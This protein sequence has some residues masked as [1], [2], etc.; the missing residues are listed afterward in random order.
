MLFDFV[1][2]GWKIHTQGNSQVYCKES[3]KHVLKHHRCCSSSV[4]LSVLLSYALGAIA[5]FQA[6]V[7]MWVLKEGE[8]IATCKVAK[9]E[10]FL[11]RRNSQTEL[12]RVLP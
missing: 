4:C 11:E 6:L 7:L 3:V 9:M 2:Y 10:V 5:S 1:Q 12:L 8:L